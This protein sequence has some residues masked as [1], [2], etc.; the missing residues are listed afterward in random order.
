[1]DFIFSVINY[2]LLSFSELIGFDSLL[3]FIASL[4]FAFWIFSFSKLFKY[5]SFNF[6]HVFFIF[7]I[8]YCLDVKFGSSYIFPSDENALIENIAG[9]PTLSF[10][11]ELNQFFSVNAQ[12]GNYFLVKEESALAYFD[13]P[14][15]LYKNKDSSIFFVVVESFG[16]IKNN[17]IRNWIY[18]PLNN[19]KFSSKYLS[20]PFKGATTSGE[21]RALCSINASYLNVHNANLSS[22][23]PRKLSNLGWKTI[24]YHGFSKSMFNRDKW[25]YELGL[26]ELYFSGSIPSS[27]V[28]GSLFKG[29]CD[30]DVIIF[31]AQKLVEKNVFSYVLTLDTHLPVTQIDVDDDLKQMCNKNNIHSI[32]CMHF[33]NIRNTLTQIINSSV[34]LKNLPFII[35]VGDHAPPFV[36]REYRDLFSFSNVPVIILEPVQELNN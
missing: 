9:S 4:F 12:S 27:S 30:R 1:M 18:Q 17:S 36:T 15:I 14:Q 13:V 24:G 8:T 10:I 16:Y 28:C 2:D 29:V 33:Q 6:S 26:Q 5:L 32:P 22:C 34:G 31:A 19:S 7:V 20:L 25:W 21:I 11:F 35:I 3:V 23:L